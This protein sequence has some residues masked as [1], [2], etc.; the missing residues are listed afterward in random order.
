[1]GATVASLD[2]VLGAG[3]VSAEGLRAFA[4]A[5]G[6]ASLRAAADATRVQLE[7]LDAHVARA[8]GAMAPEERRG[9][10]VV[11][12]GNHQARARSLPLQYFQKLFGEAPGE[13][14]RVAY[15]EGASDEAGALALV[16]TRRLD[17]AI[18]G[19]FF[20]E[21]RRL[22]RDGLGD[23]ARERLRGFEPSARCE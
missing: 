12:T 9:L 17:R 5:A 2:G 23:A 7:A 22:Q 10:Q 3:R 21:P 13:E 20:G 11:V 8:L 1:L 19:A 18:A 6:P 15:A 4:A 16:G 14:R